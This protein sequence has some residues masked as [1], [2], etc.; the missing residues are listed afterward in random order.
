L[1]YYLFFL[2]KNNLNRRLASHITRD[3]IRTIGNQKP[4]QKI[5]I[6]NLPDEYNGSYIFRLGLPEALDIYRLDPS[7]VR[8]LNHLLWE[9]ARIL[10]DSILP[11]TRG[12]D[13]FIPPMVKI[14][15][16]DQDSSGNKPDREMIYINSAK[17]SLLYWD[18]KKLV[19][20]W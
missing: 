3:I 5:A 14:R 11:D 10:P 6:V 9:R 16:T 20:L 7:R 18:K 17:E 8:V 1:G 4:G 15:I 2:E 12:R 19:R 13:L